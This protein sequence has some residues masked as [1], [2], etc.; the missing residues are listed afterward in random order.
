MSKIKV[1]SI[2]KK[3]S[4]QVESI[5]YIRGCPTPCGYA[6]GWEVELSCKIT[7]KIYEL[8]QDEN[9]FNL[10]EFDNVSKMLEWANNLPD[11]NK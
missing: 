9:I 5:S 3:K 1:Q 2:L 4:I 10:M 8:T 6:N 7:D 11:L